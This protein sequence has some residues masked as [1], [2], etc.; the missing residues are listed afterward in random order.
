MDYA[1]GGDGGDLALRAAASGGPKN[2]QV[3]VLE[4]VDASTPDFGPAMPPAARSPQ[5]TPLER[6]GDGRAVQQ[7][8]LQ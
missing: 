6:F 8:G 5:V 4:V 2:C 3:S 7:P 1:A